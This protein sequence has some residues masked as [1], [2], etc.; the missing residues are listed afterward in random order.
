MA[1]ISI[2]NGRTYLT[3]AEA[4][5]H[6]DEISPLWDALVALM[7]DDTRELVAA[8]AAP[9]TEQEFLAAYLSVAPE[10][11]TIG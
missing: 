7:D 3:A 1:Q 4:V 6:W 2:N 8:D 11:L 10:D 9:C 5:E